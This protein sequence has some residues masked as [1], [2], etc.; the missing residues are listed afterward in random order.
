M[1]S[2]G[3][4]AEILSGVTEKDNIKVWNKTEPLK[5]NTDAGEDAIID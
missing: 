2:D 5:R 4:Y 1:S 3:V